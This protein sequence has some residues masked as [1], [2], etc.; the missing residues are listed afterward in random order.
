MTHEVTLRVGSPHVLRDHIAEAIV[1]YSQGSNIRHTLEDLLAQVADQL[2]THTEEP[3]G[4]GSIVR[5]RSRSKLTMLGHPSPLNGRH[6]WES[7]SGAVEVWSE[8]T[9]VEVLRVGVGGSSEAEFAE[10][11][12]EG[13]RHLASKIHFRLT[14]LLS[15]AITSERKNAY[16][17]A[18]Q[19][20]EELA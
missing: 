8:L 4:F 19:A 6:Y 7:E 14:E 20:V 1:G 12:L 10:A 15:E 17:K 18:I 5:A 2:P 11:Y 3:E 13:G 16:E 9:D